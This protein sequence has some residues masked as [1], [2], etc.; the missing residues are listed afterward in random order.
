MGIRFL[1]NSNNIDR[2]QFIGNNS[3]KIDRVQ[4]IGNKMLNQQSRENS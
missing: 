4:F 1:P 2:V 3:N